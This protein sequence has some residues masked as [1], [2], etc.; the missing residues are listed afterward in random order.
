[1]RDVGANLA[2]LVA[3]VA[4]VAWITWPLAPNAAAG[5]TAGVTSMDV[6]YSM[7]AMAWVS[8]S[9]LTAPGALANAPIYHPDPQAL[10]YGPS[11]LGGVPF[12]APVYWSTG[13]PVLATNVVYLGGV[14]ATAWTMHLVVRR[15]TGSTLAAIVAA[16]VVLTNPWLMHL[17]GPTTPHIVALQLLPLI[18]FVGAA[19]LPSPARAALLLLLVVAQSLTEPVYVAPAVF[20]P[21]AAV[22]LLR[23]VHPRT[24]KTG[25]LLLGTLALAAVALLPLYQQY[26]AVR[27]A[28][29]FLSSQSAWPVAVPPTDVPFDLL[30][31]IGPAVVPPATLALLA[32]GVVLLA[33][34]RRGGVRLGLDAAWST[35]AVWAVVGIV[36]SLS[37]EVRWDGELV[38]TP[39]ALL[40][41][42]TGVDVCRVPA[43]LGVAGLMGIAILAG[44]ALAEIARV[45]AARVRPPAL[46]HACCAA[47]VAVVLVPLY[48][49][50]GY[51]GFAGTDLKWSPGSTTKIEVLEPP[52]AEW[53]D[54][55][56]TID[57]PLLELP[58][59]YDM[60]LGPL[61][62]A[63]AM[64]R[65]LYH[66]RPLL[67]GYSSY[68][69]A[70]F[71]QRMAFAALLP[72]RSALGVLAR[73]TGLAG[74]WVRTTGMS[75]AQRMQ[76]LAVGDDRPDIRLV[77]QVG[78]DLLFAVDT[79]R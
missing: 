13:N 12:F 63:R 70:G 42:L 24:W 25:L 3:Y 49:A 68:Y 23:L 34:R 43:R 16:G 55:L 77:A 28:N 56:A 76:W 67:N 30:H 6:L 50:W 52:S 58:I 44:A 48:Q 47:V 54:A 69:P 45:V 71:R 9:L 2:I 5:V 66:H 26:L 21:V 78:G 61:A 1:M 31:G 4:V 29:P 32:V 11:A 40:R 10:F 59:P 51:G 53:L 36:L 38:R 46:A 14:A 20:A 64:Y 17:F 62:Q 73:S 72:S 27:H 74:I 19:P 57:G 75:H 8:T 18:A 41:D 15:W 60:M 79:S 33:V 65:S 39:M 37:P 35:G 7:W 22:A